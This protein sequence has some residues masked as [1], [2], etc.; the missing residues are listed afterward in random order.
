[1]ADLNATMEAL[2]VLS[3]NVDMFFLLLMGMLVLFMQCGFAFLEAGAVRSKN[4]TNILIKNVMDSFVSGAAYWVFGFAFAYGDGGV[5]NKF[6]GATY[7]ASSN[8]PDSKYAE[9]FFQYTF[10]ATAATIVSGAMAERCEFVA[11]FAYSFC[12]TG[13]IYPVVTHWAWGGG[14]L[15][16]GYEYE[17]IGLVAYQDFAGSGIVHV[18]GG[19]AAF[20][21]AA[22]LGPRIGRFH[23]GQV[24]QLRGHSV[25]IA[26]LG[27]FILFFGFLAF[28]GGSQLAI[29][30]AGDGEAVA[31]SIVNTIISASFAAFGSLLINRIPGMGNSWSLL[32]TINGALTGMVSACAGCNRMYPWG[33]CILGVFASGSYTLWSW[34][35]K[36]LKI[37]DPLDAV[38][39]HFGG[40][41]WGV[42]GIAFLDRE[43]GILLNWDQRSGYKLVWQLCGLG[44]IIGWTAF[45]FF[46]LFGTLKCFGLLRVPRE[47]EEKG[48]DI[49][50]HGEPAYPA[51]AY[52]HG[53][54]EHIMQ[55]MQKTPKSVVQS[56]E[57]QAFVNKAYQRRVSGSGPYEHPEIR[58]LKKNGYTFNPPGSEGNGIRTGGLQ[59]RPR[60]ETVQEEPEPEPVNDQETSDPDRF[61]VSQF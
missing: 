29:S 55:V 48:L 53:H 50:K 28:N 43:D 21:G 27:G 4:T 7:F 5:A 36:K 3:T 15:S 52:G 17:N 20:V 14:W 45:F 12:I 11:Y 1:M 51:E 49:P 60:P 2:S 22:L 41:S 37:D 6:I 35:M 59:E 47:I 23:E 57:N 54:V 30:N 38:A 13:F 61:F 42:I 16:E 34:L 26:A 24:A 44:V 31:L 9:F 18:L 56:Y 19:V 25:P 33:A 8:L 39:V 32:V 40:G 10:A 46:L 58:A